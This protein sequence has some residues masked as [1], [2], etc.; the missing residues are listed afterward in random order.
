MADLGRK[1]II[2]RYQNFNRFLGILKTAREIKKKR[3]EVF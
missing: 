2:P 3:D 1:Y